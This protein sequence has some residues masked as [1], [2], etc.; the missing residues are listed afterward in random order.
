MRLPIHYGNP[1]EFVALGGIMRMLGVR[2][3]F[4][5]GGIA[6]VDRPISVDE[7]LDHAR[8]RLSRLHDWPDD[9]SSEWIE[10]MHRRGYI[11]LA[12]SEDAC[13]IGSSRAPRHGDSIEWRPTW[14]RMVSGRQQWVEDTRRAL[15]Q[16]DLPMLARWLAQYMWPRD[17]TMGMTGVDAPAYTPPALRWEGSNTS[18]GS[19]GN[20]V[21][22]WLMWEGYHAFPCVNGTT[23]GWT[24]AGM[25]RYPRPEPSHR[26]FRWFRWREFATWETIRGAYSLGAA[27]EL[28]SERRRADLAAT[29][30]VDLV[31]EARPRPMPQGSRY[32]R[33]GE[34]RPCDSLLESQIKAEMGIDGDDA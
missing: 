24:Y 1:A 34:I 8:S 14:F 21:S 12:S 6:E 2:A 5:D 29:L 15:R 28:V 23:A 16:I 26:R 20:P 33:L 27:H 7:L 10:H 22:L 3:R 4:G 31:L 32:W 9:I 25:H 13:M 11:D 17:Y 19:R 30:S 18:A